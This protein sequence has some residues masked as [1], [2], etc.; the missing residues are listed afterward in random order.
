MSE[1]NMTH[2]GRELDDAINKVKN[3]YIQPSGNSPT[4]TSNGTHPVRQYENAV[5][6]VPVKFFATGV[7]TNVTAGGKLS[8]TGIKDSVTGESFTPKGYI[9]F[10]CPTASTNYQSSANNPA[11]IAFYKDSNI[12]DS[13]G[14]AAFS[15]AYTARINPSVPNSYVTVSGNSFSYKAVSGSMYGLMAADRWRWA[16]WA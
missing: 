10:I 3:G 2:T 15:P 11:I 9:C 4:I 14:I 6:N 8:V 12:N 1:Y 16:A 13:M 7:V 5:V